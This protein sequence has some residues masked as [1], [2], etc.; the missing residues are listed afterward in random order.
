MNNSTKGEKLDNTDW[1]VACAPHNGK[2]LLFRYTQKPLTLSGFFDVSFIISFLLS[3]FFLF[4]FFSLLFAPEK[5][6]KRRHI[7]YSYL[8]AL[9]GSILA[10]LLAG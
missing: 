5:K 3:L 9:I 6:E 10:A 7:P 1:H 2:S 4:C 8:S